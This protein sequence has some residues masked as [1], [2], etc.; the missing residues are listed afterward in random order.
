MLNIQAL[1]SWGLAASIV[2]SHGQRHLSDAVLTAMA[3]KAIE[4]P[5]GS[6]DDGVKVMMAYEVSLAWHEGG[7]HDGQPPRLGPRA[8]NDGGSSFCWGQVFLPHGARTWDG[9]TGRDLVEDPMKC[10]HA[11]VRI[12]RYSVERGPTDCPLCLYARGRVTDEARRLS[13]R[14]VALARRL[15][16]DVPWSD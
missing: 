10:A 3:T 2:A 15:L 8:D 12:I 1:K 9:W 4:M 13:E 6:G 5:A 16:R 14:R 11:V 7:N